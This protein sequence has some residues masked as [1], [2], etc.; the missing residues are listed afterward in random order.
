MGIILSV[1]L[2]TAG[3]AAVGPTGW[4]KVIDRGT[5]DTG[6][7]DDY[8]YIW[9]DSA[10]PGGPVYQWIDI[11]GTG[12]LVEGMG[13]DNWVGPF[14]TGF[15]F[16]FYWYDVDQ[17]YIG[18]NGYL[19]FGSPFNLAQPFP[20]SIPL[21]SEPN[22]FLAVYVADWYPGQSGQGEVYYWTNNV[23]SVIVSWIDVP[24]WAG[25]GVTV[26]P[27]DFQVILTDTDSSITYQYG[28]QVGDVSNMD[29]LVG[30]EC[31][32]G[33]VGLEHSHDQLM[34]PNTAVKFY[35]PD[36]VTY[37][38]HDL[39][40]S[41][42]ANQNS[43][44]FFLLATE[45]FTPWGVVKNTGNQTETSYTARFRILQ[46]GGGVVYD[47]TYD[48]GTIEPGEEQEITFAS[49][50][51]PPATGQ[52]FMYLTVILP[53]DIN[54]ANDTKGAECHV[55]TLP[56]TMIYE[57]GTAENAWSWQ[58]GNGGLGQRFVPPSYPVR[59]DSILF[60]I[61]GTGT[62]PFVAQIVDDDG[63]A[64]QPGT[65]LFEQNVTAPLPGQWYGVN[66]ESENIIIEDGAFYLAWQMIDEGTPALGV[67]SSS[68]QMGSRQ[69]WEFTGVWAP[70]RLAETSDF[71]VRARISEYVTGV[72]DETGAI[73]LEYALSNPY[74]NP[75]NPSTSFS[76][77]LPQ[78]SSVNLGIY[79]ISGRLVAN[80][81]DGLMSAGTHEI[82][83]DASDL[84]SGIY[85]VR[86]NAGE[87][88]ATTKMVLMK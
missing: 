83:F 52:F 70:Y 76:Y 73:P 57:D 71:L 59:I 28:Q 67:D 46:E 56:G 26:G 86:M 7:P 25:P 85:L 15:P 79:D 3:I 44:G 78:A 66:T 37:E 13:D 5:D 84:T 39:A 61:D 35:Y 69:S 82:T 27:H 19:K 64:G 36:V 65:V 29:I 68:T 55:M 51:A 74:P 10:E 47:E 72:E 80:L 33:Q 1:V 2:V 18:S 8:G 23:D 81:V 60:H 30:I 40:A 42:T 21:S 14:D 16:H 22:D 31:V 4:D 32:S 50:W 43:E 63:P 17:F 49:N 12:T 11:T 54:S 38:V 62:S 75:F 24:P 58:G 53:G 88:T 20:A 9:M 45:E 34:S 41:S 77:S 87:F 6:G 48:G